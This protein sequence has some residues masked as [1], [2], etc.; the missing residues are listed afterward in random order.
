MFAARFQSFGDI[1]NLK[2][3]RLSLPARDKATALVRIEAASVNPSDVK[4]VAG[5]M[6][7]TTLPRIPGRDYAGVVEEGP[8]EWLGAEVWGSGGDF[9]FT[10]DGTHAQFA[11]V[12]TLSLSRKPSTLSFDEA[13]CVGVNFVTA[14]CGLIEAAD[15]Q[16]G[17]QV[18]VVGAAGG[19]GSA[20]AQI[21]K[22]LGARVIGL[23]R[24]EPPTESPIRAAVD[25]L[26]R[27]ASSLQNGIREAT[28]GRGADVVFDTVG[29]TMFKPSLNC[30]ASGG[31]LIEISATGQREV[32]FDLLDF[33]RHEQRIFG[34]NSLSR[35]SRACARILDLLRRHFED[36]SFRPAPIANVF[37]LTEI[38][39]AYRSVEQGVP[40]R[41]VL[42]PNA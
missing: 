5:S 24:H 10:R 7:H 11:A 30:V 36:G 40:G 27:G 23:V 8:P 41:I 37:G 17:E 1:D 3:V 35:D 9:G 13:A 18:L 28:G 33:Y 20:A 14:W 26:I 6:K 42:H 25:H 21:A 34:I 29:G 16:P 4:N 38:G 15:V 31:R 39:D 19:V 12:P 32:C 2:T 22:R